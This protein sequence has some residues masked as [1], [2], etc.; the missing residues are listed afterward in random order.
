MCCLNFGVF[1]PHTYFLIIIIFVI[2]TVTVL[3][4]INPVFQTNLRVPIFG[5]KKLTHSLQS[6][7]YAI[8][9]IIVV[10]CVIIGE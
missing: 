4:E 1:F 9:L 8:T 7:K 5:G 3:N 6:S 10:K 2:L